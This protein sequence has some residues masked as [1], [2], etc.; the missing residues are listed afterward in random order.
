MTPKILIQR[1][2]KT[3]LIIDPIEEKNQI[4]AWIQMHRAKTLYA[5]PH[6]II[7]PQHTKIWML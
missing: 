7:K 6:G 5:K 4:E 1:P 3:I 2:G